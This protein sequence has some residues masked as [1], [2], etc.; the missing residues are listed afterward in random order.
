[1]GLVS[2]ELAQLDN[3]KLQALCQPAISSIADKWHHWAKP[4]PAN[5]SQE[6]TD[7]MTAMDEATSSFNEMIT[8]ESRFPQTPNSYPFGEK[9]FSRSLLATWKETSSRVEDVWDSGTTFCYG[10]A[11]KLKQI[12]SMKLTDFSKATSIFQVNSVYEQQNS[13]IRC[14]V[15]SCC[16][17]SGH[18]HQPE[19]SRA[20]PIAKKEPLDNEFNPDAGDD[21]DEDPARLNRRMG[22][23]KGS[24]GKPRSTATM[25][26]IWEAPMTT[27]PKKAQISVYLDAQVMKTVLAYAARRE[28]PVSAI[29]EAAIGSFLSPDAHERREAAIAKRLDQQDRRLAC[30]K[31]DVGIAVETLAL[32]IRFWLTTTPPLPEPAAQAARAKARRA[33]G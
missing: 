10:A 22:S 20:K 29:A 23:C 18:R 31:R 1:M 11:N 12:T 16:R 8:T 28:L 32:F 17:F 21:M 27:R 15:M 33:V 2:S 13:P 6:N 14:A 24:P 7:E 5:F 3:L 19:L 4:Q 26:S 9:F 25:I 30:V